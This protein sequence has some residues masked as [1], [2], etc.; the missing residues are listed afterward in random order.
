MIQKE[1]EDKYLDCTGDSIG[2][3]SKFAT[4]QQVSIC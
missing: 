4:S 1:E 3:K 2:S